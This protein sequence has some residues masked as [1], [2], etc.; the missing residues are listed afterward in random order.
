MNELIHEPIWEAWQS[1]AYCNSLLKSRAL[2]STTGSNPVASAKFIMKLL[3]R[4]DIDKVR[5]KFRDSVLEAWDRGEDVPYGVIYLS[6]APLTQEDIDWAHR[7][8]KNFESDDTEQCS[9]VDGTLKTFKVLTNNISY[10]KCVSCKNDLDVNETSE[11]AN[12]QDRC[13]NC[14]YG[15][16]GNE[17]EKFPIH[18]PR[19]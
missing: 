13:E 11:D 7:V 14:Y 1:P 19:I 5:P 10:N 17:I 18:S 12:F 16:L 9:T 3:Q 15:E 6:D 8:I 2:K 4:E